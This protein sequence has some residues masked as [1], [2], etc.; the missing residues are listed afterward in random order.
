MPLVDNAA[1]SRIN[2][3]ISVYTDIMSAKILTAKVYFEVKGKLG[4]SGIRILQDAER[5]V[6]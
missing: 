3:F 1:G 4:N 5:T 6:R 2:Y